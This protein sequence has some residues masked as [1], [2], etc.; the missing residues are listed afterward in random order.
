MKL[1]SAAVL[2]FF[3]L[4]AC[5]NP[6]L[7]DEELDGACPSKGTPEYERLANHVYPTHETTSNTESTGVGYNLSADPVEASTQMGIAFILTDVRRF[8]GSC[9]SCH[10]SMQAVRASSFAL[11]RPELIPDAAAFAQA[12]GAGLNFTT[13]TR[14]TIN[15]LYTQQY[16]GRGACNGAVTHVGRN[17]SCASIPRT[18]TAW[19]A[20]GLSD[21]PEDSSD[22]DSDRFLRMAKYLARVQ[23]SNGSVAADHIHFPVDPGTTMTTAQAMVSWQR[24][25][26]LSPGTFDV[27]LNKAL[28]FMRSTSPRNGSRIYIQEISWI[29]L[30]LRSAGIPAE[31]PQIV[32]LAADLKRLHNA[33]GGWSNHSFP[34]RHY[35][36]SDAFAT[37]IALC[38]LNGAGETNSDLFPEFANG[39]TR[40]LNTQSSRGYWNRGG[41]EGSL[42][43]ATIWPTVCLAQFQASNTAPVAVVTVSSEVNECTDGGASVTLFGDQS[44]D[45]DGDE[46]TYAWDGGSTDA[47]FTSIFPLGSHT[48][49]LTVNDGQV[50][51]EP[52]SAS[53]SVVDTTAPV[54]TMS[55]YK[56]K[57]WPPNHTM[58]LVGSFSAE[59]SCCET[60][61]EITV[62]SNEEINGLGD[63]D[64][65]F[66]W[67]VEAN[68]DVYVR[69][70]RS[71]GGEGR[72]YTISA[73]STDCA[74]N[75]STAS[76]QVIVDH[77]QKGKANGKKK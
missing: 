66:D 34:G 43:S 15:R 72:T 71:G 9:A 12:G 65:D 11:A 76:F 56:E 7:K 55:Q 75:S 23:S 49:T 4:G 50:D 22:F 18:T 73:S 70:E 26:E 5:G 27:A 39:V 32:G 16:D 38:G 6:G 13:Q 61:L 51:S 48:A 30:G 24:G 2:F 10:V 35:T 36:R 41:G 62:T 28:T 63:G 20:F 68:G 59:D 17:H 57:L 19:A 58:H 54:I 37:G 8:N 25:N 33:D 67:V 1:S 42:V 31:D 40:L 77:D 46:L 47:N 3:I 64:T 21:M 14:N 53:F 74:G 45:D 44:Y 69:A 52:A 29:I 60:S